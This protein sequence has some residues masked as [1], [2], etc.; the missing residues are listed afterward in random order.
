MNLLKKSKELTIE[1]EEFV[2]EFDMRSIALYKELSNKPFV[3]GVGDLFKYDDEAIAMFIACT[4]RRKEEP[5]KPLGKEVLEG[6]ILY[7]LLNHS[8]DVI[9][10]IA[11]SLP[12]DTSKNAKK[13]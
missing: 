11:M 8:S 1:N 9:E 12:S 7:F 2:M 5:T 6:D 13:N 4:L 10:L 3:K